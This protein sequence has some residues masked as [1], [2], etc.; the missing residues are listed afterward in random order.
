MESVPLK[1]TL[2][3]GW[4]NDKS[5]F[6]FRM[7]QK[8]GW[9]EDKG[10]GKNEDGNKDSIKIKKR[11]DGLGL[12]SISNTDSAGDVGWGSTATSFNQVLALL[13]KNY[14]NKDEDKK[15]KK[16]KKSEVIISVGM[17]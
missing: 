15:S 8:M 9:T 14:S 7:L 6:G 12:G 2:N 4:K 5:R 13:Q 17:K 16:K 10:L 1:D 11:S 3:E